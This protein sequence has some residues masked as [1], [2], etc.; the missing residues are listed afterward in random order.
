M[1]RVKLI[2]HS[3][4]TTHEEQFAHVPKPDE[5]IELYGCTF[6]VEGVRVVHERPD[7]D[8]SDEWPVQKVH[9]VDVRYV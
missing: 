9:Y 7:V 2:N 1:P 5:R 8:L 6:I 3:K 4:D